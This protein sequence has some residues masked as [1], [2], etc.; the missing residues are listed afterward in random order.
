[1]PD[2]SPTY[3][4]S[5]CTRMNSITLIMTKVVSILVTQNVGKVKED[6]QLPN[7]II[8]KLVNIGRKSVIFHLVMRL[9]RL[10]KFN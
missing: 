3:G 6:F 5:V 9:H 8:L 4:L 10:T 2:E 1:M 7:T